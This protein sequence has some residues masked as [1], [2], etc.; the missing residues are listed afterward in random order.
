MPLMLQSI[1]I[2][3][4]LFSV[5]MSLPKIEQ[6]IIFITLLTSPGLISI[7]AVQCSDVIVP[8]LPSSL[9]P[10]PSSFLSS[11]LLSSS[12]PFSSLSLPP[13]LKR[14]WC[15][16]SETLATGSLVWTDGTHGFRSSIQFAS[17]FKLVDTKS[18]I[19]V[20]NKWAKL[21]WAFYCCL[22]LFCFF[23]QERRE[24]ER[25]RG[26]EWPRQGIASN[27]QVSVQ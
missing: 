10:S 7:L 23:C 20:A 2:E 24:G 27:Y 5:Q 21:S 22:G 1:P 15:H 17:G 18:L 4:C 9:S 3:S 13:S 11:L 26:S 8:L 14:A 6:K 25:E 19:S 16:F 12:Q